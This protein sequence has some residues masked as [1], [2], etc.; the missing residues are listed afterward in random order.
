MAGKDRIAVVTGAN[1]GIGLEIV[2]QLARN[3]LKVYLTAR[4]PEKGEKATKSLEVEGLAVV[5]HQLDVTD[6]ESIDRF[7]DF[8]QRGE[9]IVDVLVNNAGVF[10]DGNRTS[11]NVSMDTVRKTV[12]TNLYGPLRVSQALL[13]LLSKSRDARIINLSSGLGQ[14]TGAGGGFPSYSLSKAALNMLS[15]KMSAD[16]A[17]R[18]I[19][20]NT[21]NPGWVRTDM[22]GAGAPRSVEEGADTAVWLATAPRIPNGK[23][24]S[25]RKIIDW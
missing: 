10:L 7:A 13:G 21:V 25:D 20:V 17:A 3:G 9:G 19:K 15:V 1:R 18:N 8:L 12:E 24:I 11:L 4:N 6:G 16:L 22:G 2:R 5:F 14:L 23:F